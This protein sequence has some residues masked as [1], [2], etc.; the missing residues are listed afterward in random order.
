LPDLAGSV[1]NLAVLL[2]EVGR[3]AEGLAAAQEAVE[4]YRVAVA[5]HGD[6]FAE[7]LQGAVQRRDLLREQL[8]ATS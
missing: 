3:R 8:D 1:M 4:L 7:N 6:V 2:G 5:V